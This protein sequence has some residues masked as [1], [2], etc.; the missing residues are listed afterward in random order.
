MDRVGR[1]VGVGHLGL[2]VRVR[3][4]NYDNY[5]CHTEV[6]EFL[7]EMKGGC[8]CVGGFTFAHLFLLSVSPRHKISLPVCFA[9]QIFLSVDDLIEPPLFFL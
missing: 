1:R 9:L 6:Q 4:Q 3:G 7:R 2:Q 5:G 8:D